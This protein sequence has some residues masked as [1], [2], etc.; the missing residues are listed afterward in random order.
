M[1]PWER[2]EITDAMVQDCIDNPVLSDHHQWID[3]QQAEYNLLKARG[4]SFYDNLRTKFGVAHI[5]AYVWSADLFGKK[6]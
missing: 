1:E 4:R 3:N 2:V 6:V 5:Q